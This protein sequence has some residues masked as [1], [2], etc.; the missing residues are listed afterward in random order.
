M[1]VRLVSRVSYGFNLDPT[2]PVHEV[3]FNRKLIPVTY[4]WI[5][6]NNNSLSLFPAQKHLA[7]VLDSKST[8]NEHIKHVLLQIIKSVGMLALILNGFSK[9]ITLYYL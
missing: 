7:L 2:R 9:N 1:F 5:T 3:I 6:F 8:S 4:P